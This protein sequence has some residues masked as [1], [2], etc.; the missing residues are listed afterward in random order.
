M[1]EK[2]KG[3][4]C[5]YPWRYI[6]IFRDGNVFICCP[7]FLHVN[8]GD[9]KKVSMEEMWNSPKAKNIRA[10]ILDGTFTYCNKTLCSEIQGDNLPKK[11]DVIK[12]NNEYAKIIT[13]KKLELDSPPD[14]FHIAFELSCNLKC[15]SCRSSEFHITKKDI[16]EYELMMNKILEYVLKWDKKHVITLNLSGGGDP[17]ASKIF[18]KFLFTFDGANYPNIKFGIQTNG[19][20][21]DKIAWEKMIKIH[22]N[23]R[24]VVISVDA[25][26]KEVYEKIR[27]GG[28]WDKLID[29]LKFISKLHQDEKIEEVRLNYVVQKNNFKDMAKFIKLTE[30]FG[31]KREFSR[32]LPWYDSPHFNDDMSIFDANRPE[33]REF[34]NVLK[35][36]VFSSNYINLT[37]ITGFRDLALMEL[38][39]ENRELFLQYKE[40]LNKKNIEEQNIQQIWYNYRNYFV[41][42]SEIIS[43]FNTQVVKT[44]SGLILKFDNIIYKWIECTPEEINIFELECDKK[45]KKIWYNDKFH[46]FNENNK[47]YLFNTEVLKTRSGLVLKFNNAL[48]KWIEC[49][50]EEIKIYEL[51]CSEEFKK[52]LYDCQIY[53][54]NKIDIKSMFNTDVVKI[55]SELFLKYDNTNNK[56][57]KCSAEEIKTYKLKNSS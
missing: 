43:L 15:P 9:I 26:S 51:E 24:F 4:F 8:L 41:N 12:S 21:F 44:K 2:H 13:D 36:P 16:A 50:P 7:D 54:I 1:D 28:D 40:K 29:N 52:I 49:T 6:G 19:I 33:F 10:S 47:I 55:N 37:N 34:I 20:L 14:F 57:I 27:V 11:E 17:F 38:E 18:K 48:Y 5:K 30:I 42:K 32:I 31:F 22:N 46:Y 53:Y 45:V 23:I 25:G 39:K 56:W 3:R 35:D